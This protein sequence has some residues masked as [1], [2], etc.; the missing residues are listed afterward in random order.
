[1]RKAVFTAVFAVS[2][3]GLFSLI[4]APFSGQLN[5]QQLTCWYCV[6]GQTLQTTPAVCKEKGGVCHRTKEEAVGGRNPQLVP[7]RP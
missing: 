2:I 3:I 7:K 4:N 1:M 5:A 6:N